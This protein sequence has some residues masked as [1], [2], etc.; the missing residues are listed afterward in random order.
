MKSIARTIAAFSILLVTAILVGLAHKI[1][2]LFFRVYS[3]VS[4]WLLDLLSYAFGW[5]PAPV[6][7][8]LT[9]LLIVWGIATLIY[10]IRKL[11]FLRWLSGVFLGASIGVFL[12]VVLWGAGHFGPSKT[13]HFVTLQDVT[14]TELR[15]ATTYYGQNASF[16]S[17]FVLRDENG[18]L[19][20]SDFSVQ[21]EAAEEAY[22]ALAESYGVFPDVQLRAKQLWMADV[23]SYSGTTGIFVPFTAEIC[24][25]PQTYTASVPY[26]ICHEMAHRLGAYSE[27]DANFCAFLACLATNNP[28]FLY[29]AFYSAFIYCYNALYEQS[30]STASAVWNA[31]LSDEVQHDLRGANAY[32]AVYEGKVQ[33][34]AQS[35]NDVYLKAF[36]EEGVRSYGMVSDA[37]IAWY[38]KQMNVA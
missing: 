31:V 9:I 4:E 10:D 21:S 38:R 19:L 28:E 37:L 6:W 2:E 13:E 11:R 30:A 36:E 14:L 32:Y 1:P 26:T 12:F 5:I 27:E 23:F 18:D 17:Q 20:P 15:D 25:N 35:V 34:I 7:Q 16:F 24:V 29:S 8:I 33:E 3:V 22:H